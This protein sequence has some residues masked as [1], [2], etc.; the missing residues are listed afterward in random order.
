VLDVPF[1]FYVVTQFGLKVATGNN[2]VVFSCISED[3]DGK[4]VRGDVAEW[5]HGF[6]F[7]F[8]LSLPF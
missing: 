5:L 6:M 2:C 8:Y 1:F 3:A 4:T 7:V